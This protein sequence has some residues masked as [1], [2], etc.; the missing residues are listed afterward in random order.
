[1]KDL[2]SFL[3]AEIGQCGAISVESF[4][5]LA[6]TGRPDSYYVQRDPIGAS[7]DFIT[8]P[9]ISQVFGECV[10]LWCVDLWMKL[11]SPKRFK[12]VELGPGRGTLMS[13][14]LRSARIRPDFLSSATIAL[15]E[16]NPVLQQLQRTTLSAAGSANIEW[17][18][19]FEDI[20]LDCQTIIVANEFFDALPSR[21]FIRLATGWSERGVAL[22]PSGELVFEALPGHDLA[23]SIP[24]SLRAAEEG[25]IFEYCQEGIRLAETIAKSL[26]AHG[27]GVLVID[28]GHVGPAIGDTLQAMR[29]H[30]WPGNVREL[31]NVCWRL[32]ALAPG[33]TITTNDLQGALSSGAFA[34]TRGQEWDQVLAAWVRMRLDEGVENLHAEARE[35]YIGRTT[36]YYQI[37]V[38]NQE[39]K[40]IATFESSVVR[41]GDN[42]TFSLPQTS[43]DSGCPGHS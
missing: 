16:V 43:S 24:L 10:G 9:E 34:A 19:K 17:Y 18:E 22:S 42:I 20:P 3:K 23:A 21:Q 41:K 7:G 6:L 15:V 31:E 30:D 27:G 13:D 35:R 33:E 25:S 12:L 38:T 28:Y 40:L 29:A 36:G 39:G 8:A 11:G 2:T 26:V 4:V 32:A 5:R 14:I 37:D 1:M